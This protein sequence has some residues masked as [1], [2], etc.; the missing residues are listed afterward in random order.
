MP[1]DLKAYCQRLGLDWGCQLDEGGQPVLDAE[2]DEQLS[3]SFAN[4]GLAVGDSGNSVGSGTL[5]V[6]TRRIVWVA[7]AAGDSSSSS[8]SSLSCSYRQ[9][10]MHAV[11]RD[12]E[13]FG[14]PCVYIQLDEGSEH[15]MAAADEGEEEE[16][17][18]LT[19][20]LRLV[21]AE[22]AAVEAIFSKLCECSALNPDSDVEDE[23]G[24]QLFFDE[25]EVLA[26]LPDEQR[27]AVLAARAEGALGLGD[28]EEDDLDELMADDPDRFEDDEEGEEAGTAGGA[29]NGTQQ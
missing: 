21:P 12:A 15:G 28:G 13:A 6:T 7:A 24:A 23:A 22:E 19:A 1:V 16:E 17:E 2:A 10:S 27:A 3:S 14:R 20:E 5:F 25:A 26:G 29:A 18:E 11:S 8:G 9:I 4:V